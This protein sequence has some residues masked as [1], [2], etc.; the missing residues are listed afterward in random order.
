M[1]S[2]ICNNNNII[3]FNITYRECLI[4]YLNLSEIKYILH[5][6]NIIIFPSLFNKTLVLKTKPKSEDQKALI[7][8]IKNELISE[9]ATVILDDNFIDTS[10]L[11]YVDAQ[12]FISL[13]FNENQK[14]LILY[15]PFKPKQTSILLTKYI[16]KNLTLLYTNITYKV[17]NIWSRLKKVHY[18]N[19][20][21][22][23]STPTLVVEIPSVSL[24][25]NFLRNFG[26]TLVNSILEELGSKP[27]NKEVVEIIF[28]LKSFEKELKFSKQLYSD[29]DS[30]FQ[31][32]N[33]N[34]KE[35]CIKEFEDIKLKDDDKKINVNEEHLPK[36]HTTSKKTI[37]NSKRKKNTQYISKNLIDN[38]DQ[39]YLNQELP[40]PLMYPGEGPVYKFQRTIPSTP[41][42][43]INK[44]H[45]QRDIYKLKTPKLNTQRIGLM[46]GI[47]P[48][49]IHYSYWNFYY[50][51]CIWTYYPFIYKDHFPKD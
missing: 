25:E 8:Y 29:K 6:E 17:A 9:G 32:I 26:V 47:T 7:E 5:N 15:L 12:I 14:D 46:P 27:S 40:Y 1:G 50:Q 38:T 42:I 41:N 18:W 20:F 51:N 10:Y 37:V 35:S 21:L 22:C 44:E 24:Y 39:N 2:I 13:T 11:Q 31:L 48:K 30:D 36:T 45:I 16:L 33:N 34:A 28:K 23:N 43:H 3:D 19:Y 4:D 49:Y